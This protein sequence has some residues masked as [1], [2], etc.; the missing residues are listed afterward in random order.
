[1]GDAS[2]LVPTGLA[3]YRVVYRDLIDA[4]RELPGQLIGY[5]VELLLEN[6]TTWFVTRYLTHRH[7]TRSSCSP[8]GPARLD[9]RLPY[10]LWGES[11]LE[12]HLNFIGAPD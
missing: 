5:P 1:M 6:L 2:S 10:R 4:V 8:A 9:R 3:K 12:I 11:L 7:A